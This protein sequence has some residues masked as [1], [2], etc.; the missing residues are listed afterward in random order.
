MGSS[1][2][3]MKMDKSSLQASP[4]TTKEK[5]KEWSITLM[6]FFHFK[7]VIRRARGGRAK[8]SMRMASKSSKASARKTMSE[9][10]KYVMDGCVR[11]S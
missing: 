4:R 10:E 9:R 2:D 7:E 5:A 1:R 3:S 11:Y 8:G 6:E